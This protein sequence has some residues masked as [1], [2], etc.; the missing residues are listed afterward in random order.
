[1]I[2]GS[3]GTVPAHDD[4]KMEPRST[5]PRR[6]RVGRRIALPL[7]SLAGLALAAWAIE[8]IGLS[9]IGHA[10]LSADI[11]WT[12]AALFVMCS[13]MV[14]RAEAW[15]TVLRAA[16]TL[17]RRRDAVRGTM[18]GVLMSAALPGRLGEPAR[19]FVVSRRLGDTRRWFATVAGTVFAQTLLNIVALGLLAAGAVAGA[20]LFKGHG[21]AIGLA[22]AVPVAIAL[23]IVVAPPLLRRVQSSRIRFVQRTARLAAAQMANIRRGLFVFRRPGTGVHATLAQLSAWALQWLACYTLILAFGLEHRSGLA[24]AAGVLLA[25]NITAVLPATPSN[26]GIFQAAC[27]VVLAAYGTGKGTALAYG[28]V[29]QAIEVTTALLLG[30]PALVSEGLS[31]NALRRGAD[32]L[33]RGDSRRDAPPREPPE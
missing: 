20:G 22:L 10:L 27:V 3:P 16:G 1:V 25:V 30:V 32:E 17:A 18:I 6:R 23:A 29:L 14:L 12:L 4:V 24:A 19:A 7:V 8:R 15:Y 28:I 11:R 13:S 9:R 2:S 31:W 5:G 33:I 26:V 21:F